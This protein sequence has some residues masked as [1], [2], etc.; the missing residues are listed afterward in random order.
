MRMGQGSQSKG[1]SG[2]GPR[3]QRGVTS[4]VVAQP[5]LVRVC[6]SLLRRVLGR[7]VRSL[8]SALFARLLLFLSLERHHHRHDTVYTLA[9]GFMVA[10]AERSPIFPSPP[11]HWQSTGHGDCAIRFLLLVPGI[12]YPPVHAAPRP[13]LPGLPSSLCPGPRSQWWRWAPGRSPHMA[14]L[15]TRSPQGA[16]RLAAAPSQHLPS[17]FEVRA[18]R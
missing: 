16:R 6:P 3:T 5:E 7:G 2:L 14:C 12:P 17:A 1:S 4:V 13:F 15:A 9:S 18:L 10:R 11:T 8:G